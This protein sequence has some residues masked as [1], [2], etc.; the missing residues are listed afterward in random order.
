MFGIGIGKD[1]RGRKGKGGKLSQ[2]RPGQATVATM[3]QY[4]ILT[5]EIFAIHFIPSSLLFHWLAG[6]WL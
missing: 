5:F 1:K 6:W 3:F 2:A 4:I